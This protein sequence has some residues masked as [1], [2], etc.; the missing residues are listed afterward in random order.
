MIQTPAMI[1]PAIIFP[2]ISAFYGSILALILVGLSAWVIAGRGSTNTMLGD[3]G[4]QSM[5][6]R[7]RAHANFIEYVPMAL[8]IIALLEGSG[9][10]HGLVRILLIV[11]VIAR[12]LHPIGMFAPDKT[13][14][15]LACRGGGIGGTF[16]VI[17]VAAL[18][19]LFRAT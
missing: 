5:T 7:I 19:L 3:G 17:L 13:P 18:D 6:R 15:Q 11:L 2:A 9:A 10:S 4:N 14:Q 1:V 12:I 16:L 8:V